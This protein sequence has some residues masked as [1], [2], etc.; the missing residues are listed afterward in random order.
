MFESYARLGR[1][2]KAEAIIRDKL[3]VEETPYLYCLLG[4]TTDDIEYYVKSWTL[5]KEKYPRAQKSLGNH[6]FNLKGYAE[7]IPYFKRSLELNSMQIDVWFRLAFAAMITED[8]ELAASAYRRVVQFEVYSFEAWNNLS[9]AYI[10][11]GQKSRSWKTLQEAIKCNYD[12]WR[13]WE[14]YIAVCVDIGAFAEAIHS[15]HRLIDIKGKYC[16]DQIAEILVNAISNQ[17]LDNNLESAAKLATKAQELFGRISATSSGSQKIWRL[18]AKLL[19]NNK[20]DDIEK[21]I[22]CLQKCHRSAIQSNQWEKNPEMI[23]DVLKHCL[24][25]ADEYYECALLDETKAFRILSNC[26]MTLNSILVL[27]EKNKFIWSQSDKNEEIQN[28]I[29]ECEN[30]MQFLINKLKL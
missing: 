13:I 26:K 5:S 3:K 15:W 17:I 18:Y 30:K 29:K 23:V 11:L 21:V 7:S 14:N 8:Y 10:K 6:Y 4:D 9:K 12:E 22:Q 25:L 24:L 2:D 27:L 1:R 19:L 16:D 20:V 28:L